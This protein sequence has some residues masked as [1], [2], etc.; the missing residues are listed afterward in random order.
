M[1]SGLKQAGVTSEL[2]VSVEPATVLA[3]M[4]AQRMLSMAAVSSQKAPCLVE[5]TQSVSATSLLE[6][7]GIFGQARLD[8][9]ILLKSAGQ[10]ATDSMMFRV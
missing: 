1:R 7:D 6:A 2:M 8:S 9:G 3:M 10:S 4:S 5:G